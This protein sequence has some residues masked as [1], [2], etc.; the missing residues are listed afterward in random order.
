MITDHVGIKG[1][2][3]MLITDIV[4]AHAPPRKEE[5]HADY[6][7]KDRTGGSFEMEKLS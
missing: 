3:A 2:L 6:R 1:F 7:T 5:P 4:R